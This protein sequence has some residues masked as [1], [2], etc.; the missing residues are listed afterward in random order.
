MPARARGARARSVLPARGPRLESRRSR[1]E[2]KREEEEEKACVLFFFS[3][4]P[5][6]PRGRARFAPLSLSLSLS[7]SRFLFLS[8]S[9]ALVLPRRN[10]G[11]QGARF[12]GRRGPSRS[13]PSPDLEQSVR[14]LFQAPFALFSARHHHH[15]HASFLFL[16]LSLSL[17]IPS[18]CSANCSLECLARLRPRVVELARLLLLEKKDGMEEEEGWKR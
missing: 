5:P 17:A 15:Q 16:S 3:F 7:A 14:A 10:E 4:S 11:S 18:I 9:G 2:K 13:N 1:K 8:S 6:C 12:E